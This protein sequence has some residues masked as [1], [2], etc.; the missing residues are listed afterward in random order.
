ML[1]SLASCSLCQSFLEIQIPRRNC[2]SSTIN[3]RMKISALHLA[4]CTHEQCLF[5]FSLDQGLTNVAGFY[6]A[7]LCVL[8]LGLFI[9]NVF[10]KKNYLKGFKHYCP[11]C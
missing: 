9:K 8:C 11:K 5:N 1:F 7:F 10:F 3:S 4:A 2:I 6:L